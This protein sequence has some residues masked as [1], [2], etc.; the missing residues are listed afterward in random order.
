MEAHGGSVYKKPYLHGGVW[1]YM[2]ALHGAGTHMHDG[3]KTMDRIV[4]RMDSHHAS[5]QKKD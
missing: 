4:N 5:K 1:R 2:E 3:S